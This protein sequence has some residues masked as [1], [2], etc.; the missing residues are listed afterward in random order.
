MP[1]PRKRLRGWSTRSRREE[2][3]ADGCG[4]GGGGARKRARR[5]IIPSRERERERARG[6]EGGRAAGKEEQRER[7]SAEIVDQDYETSGL[8]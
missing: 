3:H 8:R 1:G 6:R 4:E 2:E 5:V 7:L